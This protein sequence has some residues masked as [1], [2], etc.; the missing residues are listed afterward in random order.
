MHRL[1]KLIV[2]EADRPPACGQRTG[3]C[4]EKLGGVANFAANKDHGS[5][6][7]ISLDMVEARWNGVEIAGAQAKVTDKK[8]AFH[9]QTFFDL[10]VA[11]R[12]ETRIGGD[13]H[14]IRFLTFFL[15]A[16]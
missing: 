12:G 13:P 8:F 9:D 1:G 16:K 6:L 15:I 5:D 11:M 14:K 7:R 3:Y 2:I 4:R 10:F